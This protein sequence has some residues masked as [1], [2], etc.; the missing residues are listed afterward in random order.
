MFYEQKNL[1]DK[2]LD[3]LS[4][5]KQKYSKWRTGQDRIV[6]I[7]RPD[8]G[9]TS[10]KD[11][12]FFGADIYEGTP[13]YAV[14]TMATA[15]HG[16]TVS[17]SIDWIKY[18]MGDYKLRGIDELDTWCQDIRD[19]MTVV[20]RRS[21]FYDIQPQFTKDAFSIGSPV[22]F[23]EEDVLGSRIVWTP[24]YYRHTYVFYNKWNESEGVIIE[25]TEWTAKQVFDKFVNAFGERGEGLRKSKLS[26]SLNNALDKGMFNQKIT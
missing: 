24:A 1:Y 21:N 9:T 3:R 11:G 4:Q 12:D 19:H 16:N 2:I 5:Q 20:Y 7:F 22:I 14:D 15:F 17:K 25:D 13:A 23:G 6:E 10:D 18:Q 8:M 26:T